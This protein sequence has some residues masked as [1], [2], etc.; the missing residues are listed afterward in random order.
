MFS[1]HKK[2]PLAGVIYAT[3]DGNILPIEEIPDEVFASKVL[4][5]GICILPSNGRVYAPVEGVIESIADSNH[6][7]GI[8]A[9]DGADIM[10][11]IGVNTVEL[12]GRGFKPMV[13]LDQRVKAG[14]LLC[15]IDIPLIQKAGY[16][17]HT[18][19]LLTNLD[20]FKIVE[21]C[22]GDAAGGKTAAF[23]YQKLHATAASG[24]KG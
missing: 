9:L 23:R 13:H 1:L 7:F 20:T 15:Q 24:E 4:G 18:A 5:N 22:Y 17:V 16:A 14:D 2:E 3:Q 11:H 12:S 10:I 6:A 21:F 19:V 8:T